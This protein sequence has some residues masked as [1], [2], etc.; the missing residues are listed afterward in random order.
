[1]ANEIEL[2]RRHDNKYR[3][4]Q[5]VLREGTPLSR[6]PLAVREPAA[7]LDHLESSHVEQPVAVV[8]MGARDLGQWGAQAVV[9]TGMGHQASLKPN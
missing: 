5:G 1:M 8:G 6:S 2:E 9:V 4:W 7:S 3:P